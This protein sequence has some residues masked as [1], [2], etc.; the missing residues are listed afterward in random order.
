MNQQKLLPSLIVTLLPAMLAGLMGSVA[1]AGVAFE[2]VQL[3]DEFFAEGG[4]MGDFDGDG[5]GDLAV[6]PWIYWGPDFESRSRFYEGE[7]IDPIG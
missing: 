2:R 5:H 6:G 7:A 4:A 1:R 3:S